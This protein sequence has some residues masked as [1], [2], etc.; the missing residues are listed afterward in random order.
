ML[1]FIVFVAIWIAFYLA[2]GFVQPIEDL[3]LATERVAGG[4]LGYQVVLRGQLDKDFALLVSSFNSMSR[5]L[6]ENRLVLMKPTE[7]LKQSNRVL[8]EHTRFV[9]LVLENITTGVISMDI[10]G[11]LEG[12]NRSAK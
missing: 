2:Q 3:A 8:E 9:E 11:K 1:L 4:E 12:I 7:N 6:H 5:D 10:D